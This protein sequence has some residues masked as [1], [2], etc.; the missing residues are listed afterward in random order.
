VICRSVNRPPTSAVRLT[1]PEANVP[2]GEPSLPWYIETIR[3]VALHRLSGQRLSILCEAD[4][5]R[6]WSSLDDQRFCTVCKK[7]FSGRQVRIRRL[8]NGKY[9]VSCA[10][11]GCN[12][13]P[14]HW[15]Y[16]EIPPG[17]DRFD[18]DWW[19]PSKRTS[20]S[21]AEEA[22]KVNPKLVK[23]HRDSKPQTVRYD[24]VNAMLLNEFLKQHCKV[25]EQ[26]ATIA[27]QQIEINALKAEL[28]E[29]ALQIQKVSAQLELNNPDPKTVFNNR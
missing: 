16:P 17:C 28:K 14:Q 26:E 24:A 23:R 13:S 29:Q 20:C 22:A 1:L 2:D 3:A 6:G 27:Q 21:G 25:E 18:E 5:F 15:A 8:S 12:S 9:D 11:E 4:E 19:R 10:T 7:T